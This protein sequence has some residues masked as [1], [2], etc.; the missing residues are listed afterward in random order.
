MAH[1][2]ERS[3]L[4]AIPPQHTARPNSQG[5]PS[6]GVAQHHRR[7][8]PTISGIYVDL[9]GT[10]SDNLNRLHG[11]LAAVRELA[12]SPSSVSH[13]E[14]FKTRAQEAT[15]KGAIEGYND[16]L[17]LG[18]H[19]R[20]V[21]ATAPRSNSL[22]PASPHKTKQPTHTTRRSC[23]S[24]PLERNNSPLD[25]KPAPSLRFHAK[26]A[27]SASIR[28]AEIRTSERMEPLRSSGHGVITV[29]SISQYESHPREAV[30]QAPK[31]IERRKS[32]LP[33]P[34]ATPRNRYTAPYSPSVSSKPS[35]LSPSSP[36]PTRDKP[37]YDKPSR[38]LPQV[39]S[40]TSSDGH[41]F[42]DS[43]S[44]I[45]IGTGISGAE[46]FEVDRNSVSSYAAQQRETLNSILRDPDQF[47]G[48][49]ETDGGTTAENAYDNENEYEDDSDLLIPL[50]SVVS[51][52]RR[53]GFGDGNEERPLS[54]LSSLVS[55]GRPYNYGHRNGTGE[56][57]LSSMSM[58]VMSAREGQHRP[59]LQ[60]LPE[61]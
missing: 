55:F 43:E 10:P 50:S 61:T 52:G 27:A 21:Q 2:E 35:P 31:V 39:Q 3:T 19:M 58:S 28:A 38:Q 26:S 14:R 34:E 1:A 40:S 51:S 20:T 37:T 8:T 24:P 47:P 25:H 46:G 29:S 45:R 6:T 42:P 5:S 36:T 15:V 4:E 13:Q 33:T 56:R 22:P 12:T 57:P 30:S 32:M 48:I 18:R 9:E 7:G 53:H 44:D 59:R 16:G 41:W 23:H 11:Q 54:A 60:P 49:Y 17:A